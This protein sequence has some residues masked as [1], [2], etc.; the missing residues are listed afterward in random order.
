MQ[1]T[2]FSNTTISYYNKGALLGMLLDLEIRS[3][4]QGQKSLDDVMRAMY[5][6]FYEA[7]A[8]GPPDR[9]SHAEPYGKGRG[10]QEKDILEAASAV[11]GRDLGQFFE[12]YVHGTAPLPYAETLALAGL[13]L[14]IAPEDGAPPSLGA[15]VQPVDR[16]VRITS[17]R[18][19]G[20]ADR[21]GLARDDLLISVDELSLATED[22]KTRLKLYPPGAEVPFTVERHARRSRI[23]VKLDPPDAD[24]YSIE[25]VPQASPGQAT[26]RKDWLNRK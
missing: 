6:R 7:P 4:T 13:R 20:A 16:G 10:Y 23:T 3:D 21:A 25:E 2:N 22:L 14:Q 11:A 19:G 12:R 9:E 1:E 5:H 8:P 17:I 26:I 18:P 24:Q 15:T